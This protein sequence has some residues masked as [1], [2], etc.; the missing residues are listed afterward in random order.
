MF[1][2]EAK[3]LVKEGVDVTIIAR[4]HRSETVDGVKIIGIGSVRS[5]LHRI[6]TTWKLFTR[7]L[8]EPADVYQVLNPELLLW[9][10]LL[11]W[12]SQKP[13]IYDVHEH[14]PDAARIREWLSPLSRKI[15]SILVDIYELVLARFVDHILTPDNAV[16]ERFL[17]INKMTTLVYNFPRIEYFGATEYHHKP[18]VIIHSG[19]LSKERGGDIMIHALSLVRTCIPDVKLLLI[20]SS[21]HNSYLSHFKDIVKEHHLGDHVIMVGPLPTEEVAKQ[22]RQASVGLS[23]LQ[24]TPK[25]E[26]NIPQKVFEYMAAGIPLVVSDLPPIRPFL[27]DLRCGYLVAPTNA[28]Q[29]AD[30]IIYLLQHPVEAKRMGENGKRAVLEKYNWEQESVKFYQIFK[31]LT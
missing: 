22:L 18:N 20:I 12:I 2:R 27:K 6:L 13:V 25:F 23:L 17:R 19:S 5:R 8:N 4:Y 26:K 31:E 14:F 7:A 16:Y 15:L 24:P 28:K 11:K 29:I 21:V 10:V 3:T 9:G 30:A 1:H